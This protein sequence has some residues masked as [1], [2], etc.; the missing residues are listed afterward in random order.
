VNAAQDASLQGVAAYAA[1]F[2]AITK[3][4]RKQL[5][6]AGHHKACKQAAAEVDAEVIP[7]PAAEVAQ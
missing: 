2:A 6:A 1:W 3:D 5:D 7:D 4:E